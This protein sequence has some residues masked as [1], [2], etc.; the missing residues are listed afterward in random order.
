MDSI[1]STINKDKVGN[2]MA[3]LAERIKPLY[4]TKLIK[5]LYFIDEYAVKDNGIPITWLEFN[6]W[7]KGPVAP[8]TFYMKNEGNQNLFSEYISIKKIGDSFKILPNK[9]FSDDLF[10]EYELGIIDKVISDLGNE[11][12]EKLIKISHEKG[13]PWSKSKE[14]NNV[15]FENSKIS[16]IVIELSD[17]VKSN[18]LLYNKYS[19]AKDLML[20]SF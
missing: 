14:E 10:S 4:H 6:V 7:E 11:R 5:L 16:N 12:T 19:E 20:F 17:L 13:S 18:E 1:G 8:E 15:S 2:L 3:Y 9:T